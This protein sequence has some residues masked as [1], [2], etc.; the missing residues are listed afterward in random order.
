MQNTRKDWKHVKNLIKVI[1]TSS[2]EIL[3]VFAIYF[4]NLVR[5]I[6]NEVKQHS[7]YFKKLNN[8]ISLT[9]ILFA[10]FGMISVTI[11]A[12]DPGHG[13]NVIGTGTFE[14]G[15][16]VFPSNLTVISNLSVSNLLFIDSGRARIGV[17]T[18]TP[19]FTFDVRG[20]GNFSGTIYINN[21]TDLST[22][23]FSSQANA[24]Y[25][26]NTTLS[27]YAT[28][29][30]LSQYA[31]SNNQFLYNQS[32][33]SFN[34]YGSNWYNQSSASE[35]QY[36][37]F[38]VN[39][40]GSLMSF[41]Y[42]QSTGSYNQYGGNWYNHSA[43]YQQFWYNQTGSFG[44][45]HTLESNRSLLYP[46]YG[47]FWVNQTGSLMPFIYNQSTASNVAQ[48]S[49]L[50]QFL[51]INQFRG[52]AN[53]G[54]IVSLES[55]FN[56]INI[57]TNNSSYNTTIFLDLNQSIRDFV[58]Y[59]QSTSARNILENIYLSN[60][61]LNYSQ[62]SFN[63]YGKFFYNQTSSGGRI[64][65]LNEGGTNAALSASNGGVCY[66]TSSAF[67]LSAVG[68]SGDVLTSGGAGAPTWT[69]ATG[70]GSVVK[71]SNANLT[72]SLLFGN[73]TTYNNITSIGGNFTIQGIGTTIT[74]NNVSRLYDNGTCLIIQG[75]NSRI[76]VC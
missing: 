12:A 76:E 48:N 50:A 66:S 63:Q 15:S 18:S 46:A 27:Q 25:A 49:S 10:I 1:L 58:S 8:L 42:N 37:K 65:P 44:Y 36:S 73:T 56:S 31:G 71:T 6:L 72:N 32:T 67:A 43:N 39:Q 74:W 62:G 11:E 20:I 69:G 7:S 9:I 40:T 16:Y 14:S 68:S 5:A 55:K 38:W 2:I 29:N 35:T 13:A 61:S 70:L 53:N 47:S 33:G 26:L 59:N 41:I 19:S 45:N 54:S 52:E 22:A 21:N 28:N 24:T 23:L 75:R 57:S 64:I 34:Q 3:G 17:M 51:G 30:S 4:V 60:W